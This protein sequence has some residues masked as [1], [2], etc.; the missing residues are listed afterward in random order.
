MDAFRA[1]NF[2]VLVATDVAAR[3]LDI[4]NIDLVIQIKPPTE[5]ETFI[6]RSGR[7]GRAGKH[8]INCLLYQPRFIG[9]LRTIEREAGIKFE[10]VSAPQPKDLFKSTGLNFADNV[11]DLI[12]NHPNLVESFAEI[13]DQLI[14]DTGD[15]KKAIAACIALGCGFKEPPKPRSL[16]A[17][18][19]DK[20]TVH[21]VMHDGEP[22]RTRS[23]AMRSIMKVL[24]KEDSD[25]KTLGIGEVRLC[26]DG[27]AVADVPHTMYD[28]LLKVQRKWISFKPLEDL[29]EMEEEEEMDPRRM[30]GGRGGR[31][32]YSRGGGN[33]YSR[34]GRG[35]YSRGGSNGY[36]R[37]G[38][39]GSYRG[40][41]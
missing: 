26:K 3:G 20:S 22:F 24:G 25:F 36:S 17:G 5:V 28:E 9:R 8:G 18:T 34:G 29:P 4:E 12:A 23:F 39:G 6:H 13:A 38:R 14:Q 15:H 31:G 10:R 19:E 32:G 21:I 1:G 37:G 11:L 33:G 16:L 41:S 2:K 35:G 27:S 40:R 7:T 30:H